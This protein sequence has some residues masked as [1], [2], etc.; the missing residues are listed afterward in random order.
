MSRACGRGYVAGPTSG[1]D[2]LTGLETSGLCGALV[3]EVEREAQDVA[4][5]V[6]AN[7]LGADHAVDGERD[8]HLGEVDALPVHAGG[9]VDEAAVHLQVGQGGEAVRGLGRHHLVDAGVGRL[10][11][12]TAVEDLVEQAAALVDE[13]DVAVAVGVGAAFDGRV[14][15]NR[16]VSEVAF[17]VVVKIDLYLFCVGGQIG[18]GDAAVGARAEVRVQLGAGA[19]AGDVGL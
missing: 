9:A 6:G 4:G 3:G 17:V 15:R 1:G 7:A 8:R 18:E 10:D 5:F 2:V 12:L 16:V 13:D 19:D 14:G 11:P